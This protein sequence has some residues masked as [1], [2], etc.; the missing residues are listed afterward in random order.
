MREYSFEKLEVWKSSREI[1][2]KI[3]VVTRRFPEDEHFGLVSQM[4]RAA[5]SVSSNLAEGSSRNMNKDRIRYITIA[6]GSLME[7]LNQ[8]I[9]SNDFGFLVEKDYIEIRNLIEVL[10][11][12]MTLYKQS[13]QRRL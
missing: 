9:L 3:Y 7:L 1:A 2:K 12:R 6:Y 13:F 11:K 10:T 5:V 8:L 4:R